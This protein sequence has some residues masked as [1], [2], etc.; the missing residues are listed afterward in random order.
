MAIR[1]T[2]DIQDQ[3]EVKI[4][5]GY[6]R[7]LLVDPDE[8]RK[9][10]VSEIASAR[11]LQSTSHSAHKGFNSLTPKLGKEL[12]GIEILAFMNAFS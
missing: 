7:R 2:S 8:K 9:A 6:R 10:S 12:K 4:I 5:N 11:D 1:N 3:V